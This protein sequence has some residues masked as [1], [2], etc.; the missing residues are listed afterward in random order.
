MTAPRTNNG[1]GH[2]WTAQLTLTNLVL[3]GGAIW[4]SFKFVSTVQRLEKDN[5]TKTQLIEVL[6]KEK[7]DR[8]E[9]SS[10]IDAIKERQRN[11]FQRI[12]ELDQRIDKIDQQTEYN[13]GL[14]DGLHKAERK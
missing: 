10:E 14:N 5:E 7:A 13:R 12:G 1:K 6:K 9:M 4:S 3:I 11:Q 2:F 8:A